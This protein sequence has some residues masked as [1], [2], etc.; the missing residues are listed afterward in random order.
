MAFLK[1]KSLAM[2]QNRDEEREN[3]KSVQDH[4]KVRPVNITESE[5]SGIRGLA[6]SLHS[7]R[8]VSNLFLL[9]Y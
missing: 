8:P 5:K 3:R 4:M 7:P 1:I 9:K 2:M 6:E